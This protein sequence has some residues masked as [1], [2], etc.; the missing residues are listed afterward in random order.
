MTQLL[1]AVVKIPTKSP[2]AARGAALRRAPGQVRSSGAGCP[3]TRGGNEFIGLEHGITVY[4][5]RDERGRWRAIWREAGRREQCEAAT[6]EKLAAKLDKVRLRLA[7]DAPNMRRPG[8]DLIAHYLDPD[9][10]PVSARWSRK[11]AHT[12]REASR[13]E[14][15]TG[16]LDHGVLVALWPELYLPRGVRLAWEEFHPQL[17]RAGCAPTR[18]P[19]RFPVTGGSG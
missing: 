7:A 19:A 14:D 15:L 3:A 11:H 10:L 1:S 5:A 9:R 6:E 12:Q 18:P 17:G 8:A 2:Q 4:P 16:F 13:P